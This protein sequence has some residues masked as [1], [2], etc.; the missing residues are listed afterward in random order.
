MGKSK[1]KNGSEVEYLRGY[2]R[3]LEKTV[4]S[5]K[6][7]LRRFEKYGTDSQDTEVSRDSEDTDTDLEILMSK[8]CTYCGKGKIV[9]TLRIHDKVYGRCNVCE[10]NDR[11][12]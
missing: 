4:R 9:E 7:E 10:T 5:L 12:K 2:C 11:M 3:E 6:K 1:Q 8:P